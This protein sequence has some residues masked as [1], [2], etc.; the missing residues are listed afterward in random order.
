MKKAAAYARFSSDRQSETSIEAQMEKIEQFC[1]MNDYQLEF[2]YV[3]KALTASTDKRPQF[4]Q[5]ISDA[6]TQKFD[7]LIVYKYDRFARNLENAIVYSKMLEKYNVKLISVNEALPEG[8]S[9]KLMY[10]I[11]SSINDFYLENLRQEVKDKTLAVAKKGYFIGGTTPYGFDL[12]EVREEYGKIRKKHVINEEEAVY[13]REMFRLYATGSTTKYIADKLKKK[14]KTS[15]KQSTI[16]D[17]LDNFKYGGYFTYN[18]GTK[19]K[20]HQERSD[21]IKIPGALPRIVDEETFQK[22]RDRFKKNKR[23]AKFY[24]NK[25]NY[26][27]SGIIKC[28]ICGHDLHGDGGKYPKFVCPS[29]KKKQH[30]SLTIGKAK[31]ESHVKSFVR[32]SVFSMDMIDFDEYAERIN[33]FH[34]KQNM[35][36][37]SKREKYIFRKAEIKRQ[38]EN[39]IEAVKNGFATEQL[40][41]EMNNLEIELAKINEEISKFSDQQELYI[42]GNELRE[43]FEAIRERLFSEDETI[44]QQ[45]LKGVINKV[46]VYPG[47]AVEIKVIENFPTN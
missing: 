16:R 8:A 32:Y 17:M 3:D 34:E 36:M 39:I 12:V 9:G 1:A 30:E 22:V 38:K 44:L 11:I 20:R 2:K 19:G 46:I 21:M 14:T 27:L 5:A 6:K 40:R 42:T 37:D 47:G 18:R 7:A 15:W 45:T 23:P 35:F 26:L 33:E 25:R 28:G 43:R 4:L 31:A 13:V 41:D 10:N 29:A 24:E